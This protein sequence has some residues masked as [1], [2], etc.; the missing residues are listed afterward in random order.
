MKHQLYEFSQLYAVFFDK[1]VSVN[2]LTDE[3]QIF[4]NR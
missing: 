2:D 3:T 4:K 1:T